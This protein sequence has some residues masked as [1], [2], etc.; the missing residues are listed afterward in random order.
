MTAKGPQGWVQCE[1]H[2]PYYKDNSCSLPTAAVHD[3][4]KQQKRS[5]NLAVV[6]AKAACS[7]ALPRGHCLS[8]GACELLVSTRQPRARGKGSSHLVHT[9]FSNPR[10]GPFS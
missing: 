6:I 9:E 8:E 3:I 5:K 10:P 2:L 4:F 1:D 7:W